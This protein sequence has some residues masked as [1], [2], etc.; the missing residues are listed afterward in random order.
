[1][2]PLRLALAAMLPLSLAACGVPDLVAHGVKSYER[3]QDANKSAAGQQ[4][5]AAY[6]PAPPAQQPAP[7]AG[8]MEADFVP[9]PMPQRESVTAEPLR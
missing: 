3:T 1:M 5:P 8:Q 2:S 6:Q 9:T 7:A 4:Q